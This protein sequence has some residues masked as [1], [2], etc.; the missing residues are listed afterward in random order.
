ME[1][2]CLKCKYSWETNSKLDSVTC[3]NCQYKVRKQPKSE[4]S[5]T[6]STHKNK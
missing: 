1:M 6:K 4:S 2:K 3:P 5:N